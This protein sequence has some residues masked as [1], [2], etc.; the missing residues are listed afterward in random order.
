MKLKVGTLALGTRRDPGTWENGCIGTGGDIVKSIRKPK[1]D[2]G[3]L[4]S[5]FSL[6]LDWIYF[7]GHFTDHLYNDDQDLH[8]Y[9]DE[10][11]VVAINGENEI[12]ATF[13]QGQDFKLRE[14]ALVVLWGGCSVMGS[15]ERIKTM[16]KL[17]GPHTMLGFN[18][19][20]GPSIVQAMLGE[21][22]MR[23][24]HFF[25]QL[26]RNTEDP[27]AAAQAWM[28]AAQ[29]G[30]SGGSMEGLFRAVDFDGQGWKLQGGRIVRWFSTT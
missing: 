21:G 24:K 16:R 10:N 4:K 15:I 1:P 17:F 3:E 7:G 19:S 25:K 5:F 26:A 13:K 12:I 8:F 18:G 6:S 27:N 14:T 22:F 11:Q 2:I 20:T 30:Y 28:K 23:Q 9:F 29:A